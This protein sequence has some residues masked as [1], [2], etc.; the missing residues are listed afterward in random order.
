MAKLRILLLVHAISAGA[1]AQPHVVDFTTAVFEPMTGSQAAQV[2][3]VAGRQAAR[4][5]CNF[6]GTKIER[7]SWDA[8][9]TLDLTM[10]RGVTFDFY[11]ADARP[12]GHFSMYFRSGAGWYSTSF[13][14]PDSGQWHTVT[15]E[16]SAAHIEGT[17]EGWG[18]IDGVRISAWRGRDAD[19]EF[20][21]TGL[22]LL[23]AGAKIAVIRADAYA[24]GRAG[25]VREV[26]T[27]VRTVSRY[28]ERAGLEYL[29]VSDD[30][31]TPE[32]LKT[33]KLI[34]LPY[35]PSTGKKAIETIE[36]FL[37]AGGRMISFFTLADGLQDAAG[38]KIEAFIRESYY[39]EFAA[40]VASQTP[41]KGAPQTT[42][43]ASWN[44][45]NVLPVEGRSRVAAWW[46]NDKGETTGK[47]A[48]LISD[49]TAHMTHVLLD[50][51]PD[52]KLRLF[53]A[54][55][56]N[57]CPD[58]WREAAQGRINAI[59]TFG[60]YTTFNAAHEGISR[61]AGANA[62]AAGALGRAV[63]MRDE[64]AAKL[65]A[66]AFSEA[67]A[68]AAAAREALIDA[69][70]FAQ[71]PQGGE[72]RAFWCHSAF[73]LD[74][75]TWDEA[76]KILADNGF[77]AIL[78][79]MLWGGVAF[80]PSDVLPT[81]DRVKERGDQMAQCLEACRRYGVQCHVWKVNW[82][83]GSATPKEFVAEMKKQGRTQR[84]FDGTEE[85]RWLC[86]SHQANRK[87]EI[88]A[89]VEVARK[90][91]VDGI[92]FDYIRYPGPQ[93]CFCEGCCERFEKAIG[94]SVANWPDDV[95]R[96]E[97][98]KEQWLSFRRQQ[99]DAVVSAVAEQARKA[100]PGVKISAAVFRNL[101][102]D[103]DGV[104]QD[105]KLWCEK[106]WLDFVCPMDYTES[107]SLFERQVVNQL[108]WSGGVPC[109]PGIG[110]SV[111]A[112]RTDAVKLIE[113][114]A[115]TRKHNT[116]GFTVFNY[117]HLEADRVVPQLGKGIT[118]KQ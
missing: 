64:A 18:K 35:N 61:L 43:Q 2:A 41:L 3:T 39:G 45:R 75:R 91:A 26:D 68:V 106:G 22:R 32:Q 109:Y 102:T 27:Y 83:M 72:H 20:Y 78:P 76:I 29:V 89:M 44:I 101:A 71:R 82:Y 24:A 62:D 1:V 17:P 100:R 23:G 110:L 92:H 49:T 114:I 50:D 60:D 15:V 56:G 104:G 81:S 63:R 34:I 28:L 93:G 53:L 67:I 85:D 6:T 117:S 55:L 96:D 116:G 46:H 12:V 69:Y 97:I 47:A 113:Q 42:R 66:G 5:P 40:M 33:L 16:K 14:A 87:L 52:T 57:L 80:Y 111:W 30:D 108:E 99:I 11:C 9:A 21:I 65:D 88:D 37:S 8:K 103:R 86:P 94:R 51:D 98:L 48:V 118:R 70:C 77:T 73:G 90:Y 84:L 38:M 112:D 36:G 13:D 105:W 4:F 31:I 10:S 7:A 19:T 74:R 115:I 107:N 25:Q 54:M 79:N 58:L 95:R 59:G